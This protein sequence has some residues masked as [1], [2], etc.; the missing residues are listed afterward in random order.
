MRARILIVILLLKAALAIGLG[1]PLAV[2][3]S[4]ASQLQLFTNRLTDT[5]SF[6]SLAGRP[7][8]ERNLGGLTAELVRYDSVY[9]VA[10]IVLDRDRNLV[11]SSRQAVPALDP[12]G[13][14]RVDKALVNRHSDVYPLIMPWDEQPMVLAEPVLVD[15]RILG[16]VV[17]VTPTDE[18]RAAEL[19]TWTTV[20]GI[21]LAA[22]I[23]AALAA[24]P[25]VRWILGPVRR[26][27]EGTDRVA[28]AVLAGEDPEP[29]SDGTGPPE[30]R[31]LSASFDRMAET[32]NQAYAAQRAFVADASHQLRNP[33]TALSLRLSNLEGH[34]RPSGTDEHIAAAEEA[35]RLTTLLDGLLALARAERSLPLKVLDVDVD[36]EERVEV[37]RPLAEHSR[38]RL[39]RDG[40]RNLKAVGSEGAIDIVL[41]AV[42][43]NAIK[44]SPPN[45]VVVVTTS[46]TQDAV[47]I[48]V[49]DTGPGLAPEELER[50]LGRFW[51]SPGQSNVEGSGLGL[52]IAARTVELSGGSLRLERPPKGGL[53]VVARLRR[54]GNEPP[55]VPVVVRPELR[56]PSEHQKLSAR[57]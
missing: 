11:A 26:L 37:W 47:E 50:A 23:L 6:A 3:D 29:V 13:W 36:V 32:V 25:V 51:R 30:L 57:R 24:L 56:K 1:V 40:V 5:I 43:D 15:D 48:A 55:T 17:T 21:G 14:D 52:A 22:L 49:R 10:V 9:G 31:R 33:L 45:G 39:T 8:S 12:G 42:L 54:A 44:F 2:S 16:A 28:A 53:R 20:A 7:L 34:V 35:E 41:D 46:A 38:L 27:D 18:L 19:L 4:R